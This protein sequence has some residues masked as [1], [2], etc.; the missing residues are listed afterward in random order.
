VSQTQQQ[1]LMGGFLFLLP[2][3]MLSGFMFPISNMPP[4]VRE[5]TLINPLR[6]LI[7]ILR[8]VLLKGIGFEVLWPQCLALAI[9]GIASS[10]LATWRL[11]KTAD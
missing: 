1:A 6:Y 10:G 3:I 9:L 7:E 5:L 11:R 8:G 4:G 2:A